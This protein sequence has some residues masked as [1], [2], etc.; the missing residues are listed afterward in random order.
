MF[1]LRV[2]QDLLMD[3][4]CTGCPKKNYPVAFLLISQL[5]RHFLGSP[6]TVLKSAGSEDSKT[7]P[8]SSNCLKFSW[9][10][11]RIRHQGYFS[12]Q[13]KFWD[14]FP[15]YTGMLS[16][17]CCFDVILACHQQDISMTSCHWH[18]INMTSC[19]S[20]K[21]DEIFRQKI[22]EFCLAWKVPLVSNSSIFS[23]K[24]WAIWAFRDSFGILRTCRFQNCPWWA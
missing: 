5:K 14:L 17:W 3:G 16:T 7:V 24:T 4:S 23:A 9:E 6:R 21:Y 15:K 2:S 20:C 1:K 12:G 19:S 8:E 10:N 13:T 18:V 22:S 11:W